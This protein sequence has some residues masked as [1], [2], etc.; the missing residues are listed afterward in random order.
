MVVTEFVPSTR[1]DWAK[2]NFKIFHTNHSKRRKAAKLLARGRKWL[3][4]AEVRALKHNEK[5]I[6]AFDAIV[7]ASLRAKLNFLY[8][9]CL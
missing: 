7:S 5:L 1:N 3:D 8:G 4:V 2:R 6:E 9:Y